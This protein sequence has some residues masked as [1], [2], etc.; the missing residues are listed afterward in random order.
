MG[1]PL[2]DADLLCLCRF[3]ILDAYVNTINTWAEPRNAE[4]VTANTV[5]DSNDEVCTSPTHSC[6]A[7]LHDD[8]LLPLCCA[9][10]RTR[11]WLPLASQAVAAHDLTTFPV[12]WQPPCNNQ[13]RMTIRGY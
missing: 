6:I 10:F 3:A 8:I 13:Q 2:M 9:G 1:D 5:I 4:G 12:L 11:P 7:F